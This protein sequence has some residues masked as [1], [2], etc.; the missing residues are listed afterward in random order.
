MSW[1]FSQTK[2]KLRQEDVQ[3]KI[4][5]IEWKGVVCNIQGE[6]DD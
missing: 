6:P 2:Y 3:A 1:E 4:S 5:N